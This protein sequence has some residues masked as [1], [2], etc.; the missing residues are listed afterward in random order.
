MRSARYRLRAACGLAG[1]V[2]F[3][4]AW[5]ASTLRQVG[6]SIAEEHL[7]GLAA[8]DA[9]DPE[10][11]IAGFVGLGVGTI[12]FGSALEEALGG[13]ERAGSG[14]ALVRVAG[15]ATLAAGLLRRDRMLLH[16]PDGV[17]GQSWHNNLH[18][19]ASGVIYA[20]LLVAPLLLARRFRDDPEWHA[21]RL[22]AA[23][24]AAG[25]AA[26]LGLFW[27]RTI[28]PWNGIVQRVAVTVPL[29]VMAA[30]ALELLGRG[31]GR[32]QA[33]PGPGPGGPGP[34]GRPD[35]R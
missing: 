30:L 15:I 32:S 3:T 12:A 21:L 8:P 29:G 35:A 22:P 9:R 6:Y 17:I 24:T 19:L 34:V 28:E 18:D 16:P 14:P 13:R 26:L 7:S 25:T 23:A 33:G 20:S 1:P 5:V 10:I 27:S 11:M 31:P 4:A 2:V